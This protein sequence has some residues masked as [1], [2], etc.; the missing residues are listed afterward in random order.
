MGVWTKGKGHSVRDLG[1]AQDFSST[2][3]RSTFPSLREMERDVQSEHKYERNLVDVMKPDTNEPGIQRCA[4]DINIITPDLLCTH[5]LIDAKHLRPRNWESSKSGN[6][7]APGHLRVDTW[8]YKMSNP[9]RCP[10]P[11]SRRTPEKVTRDGYHV[12]VH[13]VH[14]FLC[15]FGAELVEGDFP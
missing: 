10:C 5:I 11:P 1:P 4:F 12:S 14:T 6:P 8:S 2:C 15:T 13:R 9:R 7:V 3:S